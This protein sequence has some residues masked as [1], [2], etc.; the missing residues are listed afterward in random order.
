MNAWS[1]L[2]IELDW[3]PTSLDGKVRRAI[4]IKESDK[5]NEGALTNLICEAVALNLKSK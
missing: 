4:D 2:V 3:T 5:I 1:D